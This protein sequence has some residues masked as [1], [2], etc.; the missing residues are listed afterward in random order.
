MAFY[1]FI[2]C[3]SSA[4]S[5]HQNKLSR[6]KQFNQGIHGLPTGPIFETDWPLSVLVQGF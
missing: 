1:D 5:Y 2:T 6:F 4:L 3:V